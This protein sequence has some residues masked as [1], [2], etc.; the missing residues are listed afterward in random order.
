[1]RRIGVLISLVAAA[2][3]PRVAPPPTPPAPAATAPIVTPTP[4]SAEGCPHLAPKLIDLVQARDWP[5]FAQSNGI[6]YFNGSVRVIVQV[7][8]SGDVPLGY[9]TRSETRAGDDVQAVVPITQLC[10]L[11]NDPAVLAVRLAPRS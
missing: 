2:C 9:G 8:P 1:V 4:L 6:E 3:A 10:S 7:Q 11:S 5:A